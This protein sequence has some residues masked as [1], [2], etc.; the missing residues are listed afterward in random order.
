M[1]KYACGYSIACRGYLV[2][3]KKPDFVMTNGQVYNPV[4]ISFV[5]GKSLGWYFKKAG[6]ATSSADP[7]KMY[8][9]RADGSVV[10]RSRGWL[11]DN[12]MDLRMRPGDTIFVPEKIVGANQTWQNIAAMAQIFTTALIP[13]ALTGVL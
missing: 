11:G 3:T 8:L 7:G 9:L 12:F 5:P 10:P 1:G 6:G 13:L 4:A 2:H